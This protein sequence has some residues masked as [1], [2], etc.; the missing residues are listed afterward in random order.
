MT[1]LLILKNLP[2]YIGVGEQAEFFSQNHELQAKII[3]AVHLKNSN[4]SSLFVRMCEFLL[5]KWNRFA[6]VDATSR[7]NKWPH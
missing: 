6:T 4:V 2:K 7:M 5:L 1:L 3:L